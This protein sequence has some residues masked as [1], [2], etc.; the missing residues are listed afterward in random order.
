MPLSAAPSW[1]EKPF[2]ILTGMRTYYLH[3]YP[4]ADS[5]IDEH[6]SLSSAA[7]VLAYIPRALVIFFL[8][9]L[10]SAWVK[11]FADAGLFARLASAETAVRYVLWAGLPLFFWRYRHRGD[12]WFPLVFFLPFAVILTIVTPNLGTLHRLRLF[13][14]VPLNTLATAGWLLLLARYRKQPAA[15]RS[16]APSRR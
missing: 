11:A 3:S 4:G 8:E 12:L 1:M 10:P 2:R 6:R 15:Q 5:A 16:L 7:D 14:M 13:L 9:P